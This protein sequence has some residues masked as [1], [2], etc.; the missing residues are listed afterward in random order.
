VRLLLGY[1]SVFLALYLFYLDYYLK[2]PFRSHKVAA[3]WCALGYFI[4]NGGLTVWIWAVEKGI[5]FSGT[6]GR[7]G[8]ELKV[9]SVS[10]KVK[11]T[12]VY[13]LVVEW[14]EKGRGTVSEEREAEFVRFFAEDGTF[15]AE[16]FEAWL[17]EVLPVLKRSEEESAGSGA[18][19]TTSGVEVG[20]TTTATKRRI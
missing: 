2:I 17:R 8:V 11:G 4:L 20:N 6:R 10:P 5:V 13:R 1:S 7:D 14:T 18:D 9:Y 15:V 16:R 12:P 19:G 3:A